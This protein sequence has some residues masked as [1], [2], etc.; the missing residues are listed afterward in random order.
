MRALRS[1]WLSVA[2]MVIAWCGVNSDGVQPRAYFMRSTAA[3]PVLI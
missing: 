3:A 1:C 2:H